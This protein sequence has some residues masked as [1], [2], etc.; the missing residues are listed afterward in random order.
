MSVPDEGYS[1]KASWRQIRY[2]RFYYCNRS[3]ICLIFN[4]LCFTRLCEPIP[5]TCVEL[6]LI[7]NLCEFELGYIKIENNTKS[8]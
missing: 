8:V 7:N 2:L 5:N 1:S 6:Y 4:K 3:V